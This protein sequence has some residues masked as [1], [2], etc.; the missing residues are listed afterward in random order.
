MCRV[1]VGEDNIFAKKSLVAKKNRYKDKCPC[2]K[3]TLQCYCA[4]WQQKG[5]G[6]IFMCFAYSFFVKCSS[7]TDSTDYLHIAGLPASNAADY[8]NATMM[9]VSGHTHTHHMHTHMRARKHTVICR[10]LQS[11][12]SHAM[13][14]CLCRAT[15]SDVGLWLPSLHWSLP[16]LMCGSWSGS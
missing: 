15:L 10:A 1:P 9:A 14:L 11:A 3:E 6:F 2:E 7:N 5:F 16:G 4:T 12:Q 13:P 8:I